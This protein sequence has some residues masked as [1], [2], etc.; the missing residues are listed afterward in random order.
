MALYPGTWGNEI[1]YNVGADKNGLTLTNINGGC[2]KAQYGPGWLAAECTSSTAL[3]HSRIA[4]GAKDNRMGNKIKNISG[5]LVM[6]RSKEGVKYC[7]I[8]ARN[9]TGREGA[10]V[11]VAL[12]GSYEK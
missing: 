5:R 7:K 10:Q 3:S 6:A 1:T 12:R 9:T 2:T 4:Y 11:Q 8:S